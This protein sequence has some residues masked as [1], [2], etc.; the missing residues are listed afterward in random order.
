MNA[1]IRSLTE[2]KIIRYGTI[3]AVLL[4]L[5]HLGYLLIFYNRIPPVVPLYNQLPWGEERLGERLHSFIPLLVAT[6]IIVIN[7]MLSSLLYDRMPLISRILGIMN[8]LTALLST[9][10]IFRIM[11][12]VM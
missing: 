11:Q 6:V 8:I 5:V 10:F 2:D 3:V 9:I 12:L 7:T 4:L 1:V